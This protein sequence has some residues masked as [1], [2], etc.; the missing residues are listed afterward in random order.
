[1]W[2]G[3]GSLTLANAPRNYSRLGR[4]AAAS[5][6]RPRQLHPPGGAEDRTS[7]RPSG[8]AHRG[9]R[10]R[11]ARGRWCLQAPDSRRGSASARRLAGSASAM[12]AAAVG[13][14]AA[15]LRL[16][17]KESSR[18]RRPR[19][20]FATVAVAAVTGVEGRGRRTVHWAQPAAADRRP[21]AGRAGIPR[22][23]RD[24]HVEARFAWFRSLD[25]PWPAGD[26]G[27][28]TGAPEV[29]AGALLLAQPSGQRHLGRVVLRRG[30]QQSRGYRSQSGPGGGGGAC[31]AQ[32]RDRD[33]RDG[34]GRVA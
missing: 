23:M 13:D 29:E 16:P 26:L 20:R 8:A 31:E 7:P 33:R 1:M 4:G 24:T 11:A 19:E 14:L 22:G 5:R 9:T 32:V 3:G 34:R 21:R 6:R 12:Y 28:A 27:R 15:A 2:S 25:H 30:G 17:Q 10:S 18:A